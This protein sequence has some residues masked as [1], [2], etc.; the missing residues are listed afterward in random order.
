MI[1][2]VLHDGTAERVHLSLQVDYARRSGDA[3]EENSG[4]GTA[5]VSAIGM[6]MASSSHF[7]LCCSMGNACRLL[8]VLRVMLQRRTQT[9]LLLSPLRHSP[10]AAGPPKRE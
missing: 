10:G 4:G 2:H 3:G 8:V 6:T 9:P 1:A 5:N 7:M